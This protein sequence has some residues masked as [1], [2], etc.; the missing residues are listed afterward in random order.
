MLVSEINRAIRVLLCE[1]FVNKYT[2]LYASRLSSVGEP[3]IRIIFRSL[4]KFQDPRHV[5]RVQLP[6]LIH[7]AMEPE[8][9][10]YRGAFRLNTFSN[11]IFTMDLTK[12]SVPSEPTFVRRS[13]KPVSFRF[14]ITRNLR[15][16]KSAKRIKLPE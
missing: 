1:S 16:K 9:R 11:M 2:C 3:L 5:I 8:I 6:D 13:T 12:I 10:E 14:S 15:S 4:A 7:H